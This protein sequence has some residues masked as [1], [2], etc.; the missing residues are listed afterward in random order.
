MILSEEYYM[1]AMD[2]TVRVQPRDRI[3]CETAA[4]A[5]EDFTNIAETHLGGSVYSEPVAGST[6]FL[7]ILTL[8]VGDYRFKFKIYN[9]GNESLRKVFEFLKVIYPRVEDL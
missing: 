6:E 7:F 9:E 3:A 2:F 8:K 5:L 1:K 4:Q